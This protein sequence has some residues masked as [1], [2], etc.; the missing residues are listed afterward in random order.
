MILFLFIKNISRILI[1]QRVNICKTT[2]IFIQLLQH[3]VKTFRK[4]KRKHS[5]FP[6][7]HTNRSLSIVSMIVKVKI[8]LSWGIFKRLLLTNCMHIKVF[9]STP[10][11]INSYYLIFTR[12]STTTSRFL[13]RHLEILSC[14]ALWCWYEE[15]CG[16]DH[17]YLM[18]TREWVFAIK[19]LVCVVV[20]LY[21]RIVKIHPYWK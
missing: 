21:F 16:T 1:A 11:I 12:H 9:L 15:L 18:P 3:C 13:R 20:F 8:Y 19:F 6:K 10:R 7:I 5:Q 17:A 4:R 2:S 14:T